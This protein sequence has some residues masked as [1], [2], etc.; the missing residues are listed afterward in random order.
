MQAI[1]IA[2][3]HFERARRSVDFIQRHIFPGSCIPSVTALCSAATNASDLRLACLDDIGPHY[4]KTLATWREA[5]AERW[6]EARAMGYSNEFLRQW[7]FYFAYC[8]GGFSER[9]ISNV[10]MLFER[11]GARPEL[12]TPAL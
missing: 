5:L 9:H 2:D 8:E 11:P 12:S 10:Q 4:V 3:Q 6:G 1:T 7:E